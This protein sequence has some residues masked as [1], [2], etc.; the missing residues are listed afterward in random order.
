MSLFVSFIVPSKGYYFS[1]SADI[2]HEIYIYGGIFMSISISS[3]RLLQS[4]YNNNNGKT[5]YY[6]GIAN[7]KSVTENENIT[8]SI[9]TSK[10]FK[11]AVRGLK[12][13]DYDI[14]L[15]S[16]AK[17]YAKSIISAYNSL[18]GN[19]GDGSKKYASKMTNLKKVFSEHSDELK[20]I[21][22][23]F[24]DSNKLTLT[25]DDFDSA[26]MDDIAA[27]FSKDS[28]FITE[29]DSA[30]TALDRYSS[31]HI[32][33]YNDENIYISNT[34][35]S[36]DIPMADDINSLAVITSSLL[37][38]KLADDGSNTSDITDMLNKYVNDMSS[39]YNRLAN[40]DTSKYSAQTIHTINSILD[41]N[42]EFVDEWQNSEQTGVFDYENLF[43][44]DYADSYGNRINTLYKQLFSDI[45]GTAK[46][47]FTISSFVDYEV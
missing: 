2:F 42:Q 23:T 36:A 7:R 44:E 40:A 30:I 28:S 34:V 37:K 45:V 16:E 17:Q 25:S 6:T 13:I 39:F 21:G 20:K 27:V 29:A 31:K 4:L 19:S 26:D 10:S 46:K 3:G 9:N 32:H 1:F 35:D 14:G 15:R 11:K 12:N 38:S 24:D 5:S 41:T 47:D 8:S 43:D 22:I 33:N 18:I